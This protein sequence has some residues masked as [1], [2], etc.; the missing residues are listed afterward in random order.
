MCYILHESATCIVVVSR[1]SWPIPCNVPV[2]ILTMGI[3]YKLLLGT[4]N[5]VE[6]KKFM[7][8]H[9]PYA[10]LWVSSLP[11]SLTQHSK[12]T[13]RQLF[14]FSIMC[15]YTFKRDLCLEKY[16]LIYL[17]KTIQESIHKMWKKQHYFTTR[18]KWSCVR[19]ATVSAWPQL[20]LGT[21]IFLHFH[22]CL[23]LARNDQI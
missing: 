11:N 13:E 10:R 3:Y 14:R 7:L 15:F 19:I 1:F 5:I 4:K 17:V 6:E 2:F 23:R 18:S 21:Q 22:I 8:L 20:L 12:K 16:Y 9:N